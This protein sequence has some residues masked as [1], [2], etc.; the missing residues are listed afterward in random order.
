MFLARSTADFVVQVCMVSDEQSHVFNPN[1]RNE[2]LLMGIKKV[3]RCPRAGESRITKKAGLN[4][5]GLENRMGVL[6]HK[7]Q[8]K[9]YVKVL[10]KCT[11]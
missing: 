6:P 8:R 3:C 5:A 10:N 4:K 7:Y 9:G 2:V 11:S 1:C